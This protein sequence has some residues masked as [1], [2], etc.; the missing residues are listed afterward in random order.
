MSEVPERFFRV[1]YRNMLDKWE[2]P[3]S[4]FV[5]I[6]KAGGMEAHRE[7]VQEG[8]R[9]PGPTVKGEPRPHR[10]RE[11]GALQVQTT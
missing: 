6:P 5:V 8:V 4:H 11:G 2:I 3:F 9:G 10:D 7:L 1:T